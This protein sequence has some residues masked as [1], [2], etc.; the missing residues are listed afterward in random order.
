MLNRLASAFS[1]AAFSVLFFV[2]SFNIAV[3]A[4]A[5]PPW[6]KETNPIPT[7]EKYY[8]VSL[9]HEY[10]TNPHGV[11]F[12]VPFAYFRQ[13]IGG[14]LGRKSE[15]LMRTRNPNN[16]VPEGYNGLAKGISFGFWMPDLRAPTRDWSEYTSYQPCEDGRPKPIEEQF[17]VQAVLGSRLNHYQN[18]TS[19]ASAT[20]DRKFLASLSYRVAM[21]RKSFSAQNAFS[22]R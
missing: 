3:A 16:P 20:A 8:G 9:N 18:A 6:I 17:L 14:W 21:R 22:I 15:R 10:W 12:R 1:S 11:W 2:Q 5:C 13:T 4:P 7:K 19:V